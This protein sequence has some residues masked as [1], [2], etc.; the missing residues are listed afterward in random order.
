MSPDEEMLI[1]G[2]ASLRESDLGDSDLERRAI[3]F[4]GALGRLRQDSAEATRIDALAAA[5]R[6]DSIPEAL[7]ATSLNFSSAARVVAASGYGVAPSG[8]K[9]SVTVTDLTALEGVPSARATVNLPTGLLLKASIQ[10]PSPLAALLSVIALSIVGCMAALVLHVV[11]SPAWAAACAILAP[12]ILWWALRGFGSS[13]SIASFIAVR[14][15]LDEGVRIA[16]MAGRCAATA[17]RLLPARER[18]RYAG[19]WRA[20][21]WDLAQAGEPR[22]DQVAYALRLLGSAVRLKASWPALR[23]KS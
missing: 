2:L 7:A 16:P 23:R 13:A 18:S 11:G 4:Q 10:G 21:L 9:A 17:V 12:A 19:E 14:T 20:E 6:T 22:R 15:H 1:N 3:R 8:I 5:V